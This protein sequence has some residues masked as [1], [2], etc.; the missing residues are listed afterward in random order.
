MRRAP[1]LRFP[2][3]NV[4]ERKVWRPNTRVYAVD[5]HAHYCMAAIQHESASVRIELA[6]I[7][8]KKFR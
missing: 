5:N 6:S 4:H 8:S 2:E 7:R 1:K 3:T